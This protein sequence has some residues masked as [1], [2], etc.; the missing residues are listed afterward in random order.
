MVE[1]QASVL[2]EELEQWLEVRGDKTD[3]NRE[4]VLARAVATYRLLSE[5]D[6]ALSEG[7][8]QPLDEQFADME[9]R[10]ADFDERLAELETDTDERV[11]ELA[12]DT[13]E[14]IEDIRNRLVQV[15]KTATEK[16]DPDHDHPELAGSVEGLEEELDALRTE[17]DSLE[18]RVDGGFENYETILSTLT[19]RAD[20]IDE[21]LDTLAG[22]IIDLRKRAIEVESASTRRSVV[23][24][25]QSDAN[26]K[27]V[28]AG[29]CE[30]C[31]ETVQLSLLTEPRCPR[32]QEPFDGIEPGGRFIGTA[33]ITVGD[34]P[35][36]AGDSFEAEAPEEIF[37]DDE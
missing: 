24:E 37:E 22:A 10:L 3:Q 26:L 5:G 36:L 30:A 29:N 32:C 16:A 11:E 35:A 27:G 17:F 18:E 33:T 6:E 13:D 28:E 4:E 2:P 25:L 23:E 15:M 20:E 12:E 8:V 19:D 1:E 7:A 31:S 9:T 14:R 21:K 34:R